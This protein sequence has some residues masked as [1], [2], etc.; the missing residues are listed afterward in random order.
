MGDACH[1]RELSPEEM[2][3]SI[4]HRGPDDAGYY[5]DE[6]RGSAIAG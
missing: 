5:S 6:P 2:T 1:R 4:A 3:D